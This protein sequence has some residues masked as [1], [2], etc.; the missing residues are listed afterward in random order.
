M[1]QD[2]YD[3]E[4]LIKIPGLKAFKFKLCAKNHVPL[5]KVFA[6]LVTNSTRS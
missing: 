4:D 5:G 2:I 1:L 3:I 6:N